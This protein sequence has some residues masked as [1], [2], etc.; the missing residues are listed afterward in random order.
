MKRLA[1]FIAAIFA[2]MP[3]VVLAAI[4]TPD[5]F[6]VTEVEAFRGVIESDDQL[7]VVQF[8]LDFA[9]N[10][11]ESAQEA[12]LFRLRDAAGGELATTA[13]FAFVDDGWIDG[14]VSF[15]FSAADAPAWQG[16]FDVQ[17]IGNPSLEWEAGDPWFAINDTPTFADNTGQI[18][19]RI[20]AIG[21]A[22]ED[23]FGIDLIEKVAGVDKLTTD[24]ETY[25]ETVIPL[26]RQIAPDL[27]SAKT[28]NP[29]FGDRTF[30]QTYADT[31]QDQLED[32]PGFDASPLETLTGVS[33]EWW[34]ALV[35]VG[36]ALVVMFGLHVKLNN[37]IR[38]TSF[39]FG[40][41]M[42]G[43]TVTG[44]MPFMAGAA[45]AIIGVLAIV[46]PLFYRPSSA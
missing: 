30:T 1:P 12:V 38:V 28:E 25:F 13:P 33:R 17:M 27:F 44:F 10:P 36:A 45:V 11:A 24:G 39:L 9:S 23:T 5:T 6:V 43:G 22:L 26:L 18:P 35:F 20:R 46:W 7:Y 40:I 4:P 41:V 2:L 15:Y 19:G 16:A 21:N 34:T 3:I 31:V 29:V 32:I 14:V 42:I 8:S 37:D